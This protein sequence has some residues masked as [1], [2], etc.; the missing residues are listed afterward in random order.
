MTVSGL[1]FAT[2]YFR[3]AAFCSVP[4]RV[5]ISISST[6]VITL[7]AG[8]AAAGCG[9]STPGDGKTGATPGS[10]ISGRSSPA[11]PVTDGNSPWGGVSVD[12]SAVGGT[13]FGA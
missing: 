7:I 5:L 12:V 2:G 10:L 1:S 8:A 9:A 13:G 4:P 6:S 11:P 3:I